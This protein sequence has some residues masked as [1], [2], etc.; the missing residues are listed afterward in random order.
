MLHWSN[1]TPHVIAA[2]TFGVDVHVLQDCA[3][4][5]DNRHKNPSLQANEEN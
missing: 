5:S 3:A 1:R 4:V 2:D